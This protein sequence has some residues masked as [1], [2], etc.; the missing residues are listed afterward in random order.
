MLHRIAVTALVLIPIFALADGPADNIPT[1]VRRIPKLGIE[2]PA[3]R[4]AKLEAGINSLAAK[5]D[6]LRGSKDAKKLELLPDV[7]VCYKAVHDAL[8]YQEFFENRDL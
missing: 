2:V 4:R 7:E 8:V 1:N 5:I 6:S 3:E